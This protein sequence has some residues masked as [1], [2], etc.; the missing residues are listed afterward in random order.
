MK[1]YQSAQDNHRRLFTCVPMQQV[2]PLANK[3]MDSFLSTSLTRG[4]QPIRKW[5]MKTGRVSAVFE[6]TDILARVEE[7]N[8]IIFR[9]R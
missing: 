7:T 4:S 6:H 9:D 5:H 1:K 2:R 3:Y 8:T